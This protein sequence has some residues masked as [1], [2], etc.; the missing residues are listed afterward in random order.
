M[1]DRIRFINA[2]L[3]ECC[4]RE[5]LSKEAIKGPEFDFYL[6]LRLTD[7]TNMM[8]D[9]LACKRWWAELA[10]IVPALADLTGVDEDYIVEDPFWRAGYEFEYGSAA[11]VWNGQFDNEIE[12]LYAGVQYAQAA[13]IMFGFWLDRPVNML[14]ATGWQAIRGLCHMSPE[15]FRREYQEAA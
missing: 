2:E 6:G 14:G 12:A 8:E 1:T 9:G 13:P 11:P 3:G 5:W 10:I 15:K 7:M 4:S